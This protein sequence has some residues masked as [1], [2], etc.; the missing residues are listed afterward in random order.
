MTMGKPG[1][2]AFFTFLTGAVIL[3]AVVAAGEVACRVAVAPHHKFQWPY[4]KTARNTIYRFDPELGWFP[5]ESHGDWFEGSVRFWCRNNSEGFR[6]S[7][8]DLSRKEKPRLAVLGD[9]YVWGY[10]VEAEQ[11]FTE[12]L[13]ERLPEIEI[14]NCGVGGYGTCQERLLYDRKVRNYQPDMVVLVYS[15]NDRA[16]NLRAIEGGGYARPHYRLK[17]GELR[18]ENVPVP[19][20][21]P[22]YEE[23]ERED[24]F[25]RCHLCDSVRYA[26]MKLKLRFEQDP[27][28][29]LV[30]ALGDDVKKGG[31]DYLVAIRANDKELE[32][33]CRREGIDHLMIDG[34]LE[35][36]RN[37]DKLVRFETH[38]R[39]WTPEGHRLVADLLEPV[40]RKR[41]GL[42]AGATDES[43]IQGAG[44]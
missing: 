1:K 28:E 19:R 25:Y 23:K 34:F 24:Y 16:N 36:N 17:R 3:L 27:T 2:H 30:A 7:E 41:F 31:A 18:L 33:F 20:M 9:S 12:I 44:S 39:H 15:G 10:D 11:R 35:K 40:L 26:W 42:I 6:D 22:Y 37:P 43:R 29:A 5:R 32:E 4:E 14:F 38:G 13:G 21:T 8:H